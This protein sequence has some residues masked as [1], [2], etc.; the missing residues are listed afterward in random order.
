MSI[1]ARGKYGL[2]MNRMI[3]I[4]HFHSCYVDGNLTNIETLLFSLI[5]SIREFHHFQSIDVDKCVS[6][7]TRTIRIRL[8]LVNLYH[9]LLDTVRVLVNS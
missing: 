6:K 3:T 1:R 9:I 4:I 5:F 8:R 7:G 2:D